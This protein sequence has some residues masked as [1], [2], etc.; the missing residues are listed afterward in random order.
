[1][2]INRSQVRLT[3]PS[4]LLALALA[5][6]SAT[7]AIARDTTS[8]GHVLGGSVARSAPDPDSSATRP[9]AAGIPDVAP[10][11]AWRLAELGSANLSE[12]VLQAAVRPPTPDVPA[13]EPVEVAKISG[14]TAARTASPNAKPVP[15]AGAA[16][17]G[18]HNHVWI[19]SLGVSRSITSFPCTSKAYP[20]DRV[21]RW[22]CAGSNNVY[23]FGH[24]QS[25][26]K[27]L[28]DA[29]VSGHLR[30]GMA[31]YYAGNDGTVLTY[32]VLW[33]KV[34]TPEKGAWAFA[35]QS[36][37][38]LTLQT[39]VGARSQYRLVVRLVQTD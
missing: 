4:L 32:T 31:L 39:C 30:K 15:A 10:R 36:T 8:T 25:V 18:G 1:M 24:A 17:Y 5:L 33:W 19:P 16:S 35:S 12:A 29:Y 22:G 3:T 38:S 27:P 37:P 11:T 23:L 6:G 28:H 20:G 13:A 2:A 21:Y 14:A 7:P 9:N 34:T 26:F